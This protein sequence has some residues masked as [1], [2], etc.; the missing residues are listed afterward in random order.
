[1]LRYGIKE[2]ITAHNP[3]VTVTL[4]GGATVTAEFY[5]EIAPATVNNFVSLVKQGFYDGLIF[6]R[7]IPGVMVQ[8]GCFKGIGTGGDRATPFRESSR[9]TV[10]RTRSSM[11]VEYCRWP[12]HRCRTRRDSSSSS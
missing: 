7:V 3:I 8:G 10:S 5:P 4:D 6:H 12:G 11:N 1:M 9:R 2:Y